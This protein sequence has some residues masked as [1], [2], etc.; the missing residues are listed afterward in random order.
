M[1]SSISIGNQPIGWDMEQ[2]LK[3]PL[4]LLDPFVLHGS[5]QWY[6]DQPD[7]IEFSTSSDMLDSKVHTWTITT[8]LSNQ[9]YSLSCWWLKSVM[10][11][12]LTRKELFFTF[13]CW[14][15][16]VGNVQGYPSL[17]SLF[18]YNMNQKWGIFH[19]GGLLNRFVW[20]VGDVLTKRME[21][22]ELLFHE[23]VLPWLL[24]MM[25]I[26]ESRIWL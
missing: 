8:E 15:Q 16:P 19:V 18:S 3:G 7:L 10:F 13:R 14:K 24:A 4:C 25:A 20:D 11:Q 9:F 12:K 26:D 23:L 21:V 22:I 2:C 5:L 6:L 17:C 1:G